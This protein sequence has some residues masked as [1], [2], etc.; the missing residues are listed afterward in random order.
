MIFSLLNAFSQLTYVIES[1]KINAID[2]LKLQNSSECIFN[3]IDV[4]IFED[5]LNVTFY[6]DFHRK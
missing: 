2:A 5:K 1:V 4:L 6:R 3:L